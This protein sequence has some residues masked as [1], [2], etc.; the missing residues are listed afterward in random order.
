MN[1]VYLRLKTPSLLSQVK[2]Q[3][4]GDLSGVSVTSSDSFVEL[5]A[6]VSKISDQFSLLVSL[7]TLGGAFFLIIKTMLG[8]LVDG[9]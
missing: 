5:M 3:I 9:R 4:A 7:V 8:N 1:L 2:T 6:G